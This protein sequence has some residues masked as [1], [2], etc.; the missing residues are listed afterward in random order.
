MLTS[1]YF[2]HSCAKHRPRLLPS[3]SEALP[4]EKYLYIESYT[5][6]NKTILSSVLHM[7]DSR[8]VEL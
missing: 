4:Q 8:L 5:L 1:L 2:P 3:G 7:R 6:W